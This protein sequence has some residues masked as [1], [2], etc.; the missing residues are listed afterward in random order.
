MFTQWIGDNVD[1]NL[2]TLDGL[3]SFHRVGVIAVT[4][5]T[6]GKIITPS[7]VIPRL[8]RKL[9]VAKVIADRSIAI[10]PYYGS[11]KSGLTSV[12]FRA[13]RKLSQPVVLP[14][15]CS[16]NILWHVTSVLG[17]SDVMHPNWSGYMQG[18]CTG[19]QY[20]SKA[21]IQMLPMIDLKPTDES[22]IYRHFYLFNLKLKGCT[23]LIHA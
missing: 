19:Q 4:T 6:S 8:S 11:A 15:I 22:C 12:S 18:I 23:L 14:P 20:S 10:V 1:H 16:L 17:K 2:H 7:K 13:L 3:N 21:D 5:A 9:S